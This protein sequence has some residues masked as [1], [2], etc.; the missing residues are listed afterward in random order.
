MTATTIHLAGACPTSDALLRYQ[1][2]YSSLEEQT[3]IRQHLDAGCPACLNDYRSIEFLPNELLLVQADRAELDRFHPDARHAS[4]C[5]M[6]TDD[7]LAAIRRSDQSPGEEIVAHLDQCPYC[8]RR[9]MGAVE[10]DIDRAPLG[11]RLVWSLI[12]PWIET[13][14]QAVDVALA[15]GSAARTWVRAGQDYVLGE[16][17]R[18]S[19]SATGRIR[20]SGMDHLRRA[21]A[22]ALTLD[23]AEPEAETQGV[24]RV[25]LHAPECDVS[26]RVAPAE[27]ESSWKLSVQV[28]TP[29]ASAAASQTQIRIRRQ[30]E[31][32]PV[33]QAT[34]AA[35][36]SQ[37]LFLGDGHWELAFVTAGETRLVPI[38][39]ETSESEASGSAETHEGN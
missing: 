33:R 2:G 32:V 3:A 39:L 4:Q 7:R 9:L 26:I 19:R 24:W 29:S 35:L 23:L 8:R 34:L 14:K 1:D 10:G 5:A 28:E 20:S 30:G 13:A 11:Q 6:L 31:T 37:P 22:P 16:R 12:E 25:P 18:M 21:L 27:G 15:A 38:H 36:S 17:L